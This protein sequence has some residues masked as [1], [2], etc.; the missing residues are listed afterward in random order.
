MHMLHLIPGGGHSCS[1]AARPL[2]MLGQP[3]AH[4]GISPSVRCIGTTCAATWAQRERASDSRAHQVQSRGEHDPR[5]PGEAVARCARIGQRRA[6]SGRQIGHLSNKRRRNLFLP[7]NSLSPATE[8]SDQKRLERQHTRQPRAESCTRDD[9]RRHACLSAMS[10]FVRPVSRLHDEVA[11]DL[12]RCG[13]RG[14]YRR[15]H[16]SKNQ[17]RDA[18]VH[19]V[20]YR[21]VFMHR[22]AAVVR[23]SLSWTEVVVTW[24][25]GKGVLR[26]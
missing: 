16:V 12:L 18:R 19:R 24:F 17:R 13:P 9:Y 6:A 7:G 26:R 15:R 10:A 1:F 22:F 11:V 2:T 8:N 4:A 21:T 5:S 3:H 20:S 23:W 25:E 14:H